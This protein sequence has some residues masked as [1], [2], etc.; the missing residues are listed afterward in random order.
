M[1]AYVR[2]YH[3][4]RNVRPNAHF[5]HVFTAVKYTGLASSAG[6]QR[7]PTR[8]PTSREAVIPLI[9]ER[10]ACWMRPCMF[11]PTSSTIFTPPTLKQTD[12]IG[13]CHREG[14]QSPNTHRVS[15]TARKHITTKRKPRPPPRDKVTSTEKTCSVLLGHV[16]APQRRNI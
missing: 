1:F 13:S 3:P 7:A 12:R 2:R 11:L 9:V 10:L 14:R 8:F 16:Y 4:H 6:L 15:H 5:R